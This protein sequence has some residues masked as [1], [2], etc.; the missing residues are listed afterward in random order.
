M[1]NV[2]F[3][4]VFTVFGDANKVSRSSTAVHI[5]LHGGF[6]DHQKLAF[7]AVTGDLVRYRRVRERL[8]G[9]KSANGTNVGLK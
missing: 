4:L 7:A 9:L 8:Q 5:R 1:A 3:D 6:D 2:P